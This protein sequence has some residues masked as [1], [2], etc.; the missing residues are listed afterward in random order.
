MRIL[1]TGATGFLGSAFIRHALE[2]GHSVGALVRRDAPNLPAPA[3]RLH[4]TIEAP[5]WKL[6][7]Q[8]QPEACVHAAWIAT[9]G[10]YLESPENAQWVAWSRSFLEGLAERGV[11]R[12]VALGTCIEYR[13]T[14]HPLSETSSDLDPLFPYSRAKQA[15]HQELR[16]VLEAKGATL[17]WARLFYPYGPGEHPERLVSSLIRRLRAGEPVALRTPLSVKDYIHV[18]DVASALGTI[19]DQGFNGPV[20]VGTGDPVAVGTIARFLAERIGRADLLQFPASPVADPLDHVVADIQT[21]RALGWRPQV[22][23]E[24]GLDRMLQAASSS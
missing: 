19:L 2:A 1:V 20:N 7:E 23:L 17:A 22:A 6:I 3:M 8:F 9:P 24:S 5:P 15:L 11:R 18:D 16:P 14:G 21:L 13:I 4:G 12:M 10:V